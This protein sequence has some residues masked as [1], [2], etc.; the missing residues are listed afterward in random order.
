MWHFRRV[1]AQRA[2]LSLIDTEIALDKT[3]RKKLDVV[4]SIFKWSIAKPRGAVQPR[5][6]VLR[7]PPR[8]QS[9][10][11][12][13]IKNNIIEINKSD[14]PPVEETGVI[15][16]RS[17]PSGGWPAVRRWIR[18]WAERS[19]PLSCR[20]PPLWTAASR[21][22]QSTPTQIPPSDHSRLVE[23]DRPPQFS[24]GIEIPHLERGVL[25]LL[26]ELVGEVAQHGARD[27][28]ERVGGHR[29]RNRESRSSPLKPP[30]R[31]RSPHRPRHLAATQPRR[32]PRR[33]PN[34]GPRGPGGDAKT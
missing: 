16:I 18:L 17:Q 2:V 1:K 12:A 4:I 11:P 34:P 28:G 31:G 9:S 8:D 23:R 7:L 32:R 13:N 22:P 3:N 19:Q 27:D 14:R 33:N 24:R 6:W 25:P 21:S 15:A 26:V 29:W 20:A 10:R 30:D 5:W